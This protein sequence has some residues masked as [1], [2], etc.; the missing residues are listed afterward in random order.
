VSFAALTLCVASRRVFIVGVHF[1][2][3]LIPKLLDA[4]FYDFYFLSNRV[5]DTEF[6]NVAFVSHGFFSFL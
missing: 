3:D 1:V 2:I 6:L 4:P 5:F